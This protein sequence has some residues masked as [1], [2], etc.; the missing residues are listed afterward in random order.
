MSPI[1]PSTKSQYITQMNAICTKHSFPVQFSNADWTDFKLQD[2]WLYQDHPNNPLKL[3]LHSLYLDLKTNSNNKYY[4]YFMPHQLRSLLKSKTIQM[5]SMRA[6]AKN[7]P[8][9]YIEYFKTIG[10][11][12]NQKVIEDAQN[13]TYILCFSESHN[14][15]KIWKEYVNDKGVCI[16]CEITSKSSPRNKLW[17]FR[18]VYYGAGSEFVALADIISTFK[19]S[20]NIDI[21]SPA[22]KFAQFYKRN[23]YSWECE[24]RICIQEEVISFVKDEYD[25]IFKE[26][27]RK[28]QKH[29]WGE[30]RYI[31][32]PLD[33]SLFRIQILK[34]YLGP[35][36]SWI[37]NLPLVIRLCLNQIPFEKVK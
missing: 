10:V 22:H 9:E 29:P 13:S 30:R 8:Q 12:A 32:V 14:D 23:N 11:N 1:P 36:F 19:I 2:S 18:K 3:H 27:P 31:E 24:S 37:K 25:E 35:R 15:K 16:E 28:T 6:N 5:S 7:D 33:N 26:F 17:D 4:R 34:V 20:H 21:V